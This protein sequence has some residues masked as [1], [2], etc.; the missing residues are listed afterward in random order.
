MEKQIFISR[1]KLAM[2]T[3]HI[4]QYKLSKLTKINKGSLSSYMSGKY[5]PKPDKIFI[6]ADALNINPDWLMCNSEE[7]ELLETYK[8]SEPTS[9]NIHSYPLISGS[10][11]AGIPDL[12]DPQEEFD[13][14]DIPDSMLGKYKS[15]KDMVVMKVNGESMN[16]TIPDGANILV[17]R[18]YDIKS[19]PTGDIVVFS[20]NYSYSVKRFT[21][22]KKNKR[23]IFSPESY[24]DCFKDLIIS[25]DNSQELILIGKVVFY[26]VLL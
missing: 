22:D 16:R 1:L 4:S 23:F 9:L 17:A 15:R 19:I 18:D 21:N 6:I 5:L 12:I 10:V 7:M 13:Y 14:I 26:S 2:K 20:H 3:R 11:S 25:Y 24:D 8:S